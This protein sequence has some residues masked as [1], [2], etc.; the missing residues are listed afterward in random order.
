MAQPEPAPRSVVVV[1]AGL[2]GARTAA[3]LRTAGFAGKLTV[4]G[5]EGVAPYDRPP[6]SKELLSRP[7][8]AWL[9]DD[10][11]IDLPALAD[12]V[13]WADPAVALEPRPPRVRTASGEVIA[14]DAVVLAVGAHARRPAGWVGVRTLHTAADAERLRA[15]VRPGAR[16][17]IIGAGWIGAEVA[18][19]AAAAGAR[20]TVIEAAPSPLAAPL[21]AEVGALTAPWYAEAG[22]TLRTGML[23]AGVAPGL[24]RLADG[25]V[26]E[27]D[28]VLAAV[29]AAPT[30]DWLRGVVPLRPGGGLSTD[31]VGR[32]LGPDGTPA[33]GLWAVGDCADRAD[34]RFGRVPGGHWSAALHDPDPTARAI[35]GLDPAAPPPAPYLFSQQLGHDLA[36]IGRPGPGLAVVHRRYPGGP[37]RLAW[38]VDGAHGGAAGTGR[39]TAPG[40]APGTVAGTAPGTVAGTAPGT[41]RLGAILAVDAHRDVGPARRLFGGPEL[42]HIDPAAAGDPAVPLRSV[43]VA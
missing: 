19:V 3:A 43:A 26:I 16:L 4:L 30:T 13:R 14:A 10:L 36:L 28:A 18:G 1:G 41:V 38:Y 39:A 37:G 40:T 29:G 8:P 11:G 24:V 2:A 25:E 34:P 15:V 22:V 7:D 42:P 5:A 23:V 20:V 6:L 33:P 35:L 9:S 31:P 21:G 27:A 17:V 12:D 32:V